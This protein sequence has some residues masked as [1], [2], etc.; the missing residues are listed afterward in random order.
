[1]NG[2]NKGDINKILMVKEPGRT[3]GNGFK[4]DNSTLRRLM[5]L[6]DFLLLS[7]KTVLL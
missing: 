5:D 1:M 4:L 7:L 3:R 6:M 2:Y